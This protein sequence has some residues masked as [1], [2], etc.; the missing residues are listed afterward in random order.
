MGVTAAG[1]VK[2]SVFRSPG[3]VVVGSRMAGGDCTASGTAPGWQA[4]SNQDADR[5]DAMRI[6]FN[7]D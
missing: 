2:L 4:L 7:L 6:N 1:V 5:M 3:V